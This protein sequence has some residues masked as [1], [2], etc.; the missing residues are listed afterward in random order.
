M[1]SFW[2]ITKVKMAA[3][4]GVAHWDATKPEIKPNKSAPNNPL[5]LIFS[6]KPPNQ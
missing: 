5:V 6:L 2:A 3:K 4:T 1:L